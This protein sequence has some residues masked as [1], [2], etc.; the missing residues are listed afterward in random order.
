[1]IGFSRRTAITYYR[2]QSNHARH[3][4]SGAFTTAAKK[5]YAKA[6]KVAEADVELETHKSGH[7]AFQAAVK[8][9]RSKF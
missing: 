6:R 2:K 9:K 8:Q 3:A 7:K 5:A 1:V 4:E